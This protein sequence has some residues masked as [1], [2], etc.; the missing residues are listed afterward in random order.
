MSRLHRKL[1]TE[2]A[3]LLVKLKS[4]PAQADKVARLQAELT[5]LEMGRKNLVSDYPEMTQ[6][7]M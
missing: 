4:D 6:L 5:R 3:L 1:Q 2:I 7:S